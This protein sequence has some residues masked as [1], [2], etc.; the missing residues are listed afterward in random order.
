MQHR[1][2]LLL[3]CGRGAEVYRGVSLGGG[4]RGAWREISESFEALKFPMVFTKES[5]MPVLQNT[6]SLKSN[7][8]NTQPEK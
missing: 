1:Q 7:S 5:G 8:S 3:S 6:T 4:H 2:E